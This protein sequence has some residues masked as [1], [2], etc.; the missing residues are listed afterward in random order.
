MRGGA[1]DG[2]REAANG[3]ERREGGEGG[4]GGVLGLPDRGSGEGDSPLSAPWQTEGA[5]VRRCGEESRGVVGVEDRRLGLRA[6]CLLETSE[7]VTECLR[8]FSRESEEGGS[9]GKLTM[10][11]LPEG[12]GGDIQEG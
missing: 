4:C 11:F 9:L 2:G 10:V 3:F 6:A 8:S 1:A 5:E 7:E 12:V